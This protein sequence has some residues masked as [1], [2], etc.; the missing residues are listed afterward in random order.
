[1]TT[2]LIINAVSSA[3]AGIGMTGYFVRRSRRQATVQPQLV[4]AGRTR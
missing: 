1:M 3:L 4:R 2:I